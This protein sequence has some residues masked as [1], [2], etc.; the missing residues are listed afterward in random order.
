MRKGQRGRV[1]ARVVMITAV[2]AAVV[3]GV[4][5]L[6]GTTMQLTDITWTYSGQ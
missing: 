3:A 4:A 1:V 6:G 5:V 2:V